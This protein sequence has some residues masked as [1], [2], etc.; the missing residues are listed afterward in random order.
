M[1]IVRRRV[2]SPL[3]DSLVQSAVGPRWYGYRLMSVK[4]AV[5]VV[6]GFAAPIAGII[7]PNPGNR[8]GSDW[9]IRRQRGRNIADN[10]F[11]GQ[12]AK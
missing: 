10:L 5:P 1:V 6:H 8:D 2:V 11:D 12:F 3:P 7:L 9:R 4:D